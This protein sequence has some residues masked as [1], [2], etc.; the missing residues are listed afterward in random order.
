MTREYVEQ[1]S[2]LKTYGPT[3]LVFAFGAFSSGATSYMLLKEGISENRQELLH[4]AG[5]R[6]AFLQ[7]VR[8]FEEFKTR[9]L[10]MTSEASSTR[11]NMNELKQVLERVDGTLSKMNMT[12][13]T[14][15]TSYGKDIE[16]INK[17]LD[18]AGL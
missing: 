15:D 12:L 11:A 4:R 8:E 1:R 16:N 3:L 14:I 2:F 9:V 6:P 13:T 7:H 5:D 17:R 10:V 18:K